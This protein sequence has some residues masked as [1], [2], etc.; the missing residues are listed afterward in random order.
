VKQKLYMLIW[1][2]D[3]NKGGINRVIST[4]STM[5]NDH[6]D[7]SILTLD[8]KTNYPVIAENLK[9]MGRL[10]E[11]IP[12][13][14]VNDFYRDK[15]TRGPVTEEQIAYYN[16]QVILKEDGLDVQESELLTDNHARYFKDGLYIKYKKWDENGN[17]LHIDFFNAQ[18]KRTYREEF[19]TDGAVRR[20]I[21]YDEGNKKP[22]QELHYTKDGYCYLTKWLLPKE[23]K[24]KNAFLFDRTTGKVFKY[25][26]SHELN[27]YWLMELAKD[28]KQKP[29][30]ICDGP[31]STPMLQYIDAHS[32][33][34][35]VAIH[36]NHFDFPHSYGSPLKENHVDMMKNIASYDA[37]I[38]L[39]E[40][41]KKDIIEQFGD[42]SNIF[43]IPHAVK[44]PQNHTKNK[45]KK[46]L[47]VVS[48][49]H[50]EKGLDKAIEAFEIALSQI[51]DATLE[52]YGEGEE[53]E[54]LAKLI[55]DKKLSN[56]VHLNN[57]ATNVEDIFSSSL[58]SLLTSQFEGLGLVILESMLSKTPVVSFDVLYGP[59]NI[60]NNG[61]NGI[62]VPNNDVEEMA[63]Q[64]VDLYKNP[65]KAIKMGE[66][67][68][69]DVKDG[70][71]FDKHKQAWLD[72]LDNFR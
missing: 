67:A 24:V 42:N 7:I 70:F 48:R 58:A 8:Y 35:C 59:S 36:T 41:Q 49:L 28:E 39:T 47:S 71:S 17:L 43:V 5:L 26:S 56:S 52:I 54:N 3:V 51:P 27:A 10:K 61:V 12:L 9:R 31:G 15:Y 40:Q 46:V 21:Y 33:Y 60:I 16:Q 65:E 11:N 69:V 66:Q 37:M 34:K 44:A 19:S 14:N 68:F 57:Y 63:R 62:L 72:L 25:N 18:R 30:F 20:R 6:Y 4:R 53:R 22:I 32:M 64:I 13:L 2:I 38:V 1:D 55:T 23:R 29:I 45:N 50:E